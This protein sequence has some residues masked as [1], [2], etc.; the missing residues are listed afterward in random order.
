M[1]KIRNLNTYYGAIHALKGIDL[2]VP[3]GKIVTLVGSN[4]AGKSTTVLSATGILK[5]A[6]GSVIELNGENIA[7]MGPHK[8]VKRGVSLSPEGRE[9]FPS[10]T[11]EENLRL[12]AFPVRNQKKM[13]SDGYERV[14]QL[15]PRLK[16]RL[17]QQ[18]GTLSG[19]EQQMLAIGRSLMSNP[20][21]LLLDEPSLGLAPNLVKLIFDLIRDNMRT[22]ALDIV[23]GSTQNAAPF[24]SQFQILSLA[25]LFPNR[26][27]FEGLLDQDGQLFQYIQGLYDSNGLGLVLLGLSNGGQRDL[28]TNKPIE[29]VADLKNIKMRTTSSATEALVWQALGTIPTAMSF[30][31]IYSAVQSNT[32]AAFE[33]TLAAFDT[34]ALYEVANYHIK[35]AHQF[36]PTH[37]TIGEISY[38]RLPEEFQ[39]LLMEVGKEAA[40]LGSQIADEADDTLLD[41]L[42]EDHGLI[43]CEPDP[44]EFKAI[45]EEL[46]PKIASDC[47]GQELLDLINGL[48]Q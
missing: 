25:Y 33:C 42:V 41:S 20:K 21:L 31:D 18:A 30:N 40:V 23:I 22:G 45:V 36:T 24:V 2:D 4:G 3:E 27:V 12:G 9:V 28:H 16:E 8:I 10:L 35:T 13:I 29:S 15:F 17:K 43:V 26:D 44:A 19:G 37:I 46:Y 14:C 32:V 48:I 1:L 38:N 7:N 5:V 11:V 47:D 39:D 34:N 6:E